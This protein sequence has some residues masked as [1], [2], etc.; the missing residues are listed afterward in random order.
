MPSRDDLVAVFEDTE[1]WYQSDASLK[2]A[3][4]A[5]IENTKLYMEGETPALPPEREKRAQVLVNQ[6]STLR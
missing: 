1:A 3:V 2:E 6:N 4:K 5:S